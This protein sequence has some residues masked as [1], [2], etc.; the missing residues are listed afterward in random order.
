MFK[1][2]HAADIHLDSPLSG[3]ERYEGAPVEEIQGATR[4]ALH[5]LIDLAIE[6]QVAFVL[7]VGDL[8]DG[9]WRDYN[10]GLYFTRQMAR[11]RDADIRAFVV[12]GNHDAASQ[13]SKSLRPPDNVH[14]LSTRAPE[15]VVLEHLGVAIHGQGFPTRAVVD[16]LTP[17]YPLADPD[18]FNVGLLHTSLDGRPGHEPYA[19]CTTDSLCSRGYQY[20][21]LGHVHKRE[22]VAREPWVIFP[23]NIQGRH[24][25]E[26]GAKGCT[27]VI[28]EEK[29]VYECQ[30][31]VVDVVR[32]ADCLVD[33]SD[34]ESLD[35]VYEQV[36]AAL[37]NALA[38]AEGRLLAARL[39]FVGM[40]PLH[41]KL[42]AAQ[43]QVSNEC[44]ALAAMIG[45]GD[46]WIEKVLFETRRAVSE[47]AALVRDDAFGGLLRAIRDLELDEAQLTK[48]GD[49]FGT[50]NARLPI[51]LRTGPEP[52]DP[53][54]PSCIRECLEDVKALLLDR[55]LSEGREERE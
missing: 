54:D 8:Y 12:A 35:A 33:L 38:E 31:R 39:R 18:L 30:H 3:L 37:I 26:T 29:T 20:W 41:E 50:L 7:L 13:L 55:L 24:I 25:R 34:A 22:I 21:A 43:E 2:L 42:R 48:L 28:V 36:G 15:T 44:R 51:E 49:E 52:F 1:F 23:G 53:T 5:N 27:L 45:T 47:E 16:D 46:L 4:R 14:V 17:N 6:E 10:T 32:W 40:C 11:L 9:D 19:P